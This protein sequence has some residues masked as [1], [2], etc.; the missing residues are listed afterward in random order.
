MKIKSF[1]AETMDQAFQAA[2]TEMGEEALILNTREAPSEFRHFGK[3]EVVCACANPPQQSAPPPVP[4]T[5]PV[6]ST[7]VIAAQY[8][9]IVVLVGPSGAGKTS[10]C[11][12]IA[13]KAKCAGNA[14]PALL[15]WDSTRVG[16][17][18]LLRSFADIS[19]IPIRELE[20]PEDLEASLHELR[21]HDLLIVDTPAL[22]IDQDLALLIAAAHRK[23]ATAGDTVETH[24]VLSG[25]FSS[26]YLQKCFTRYSIF[27]PMFLLPTHLDEATLDL[28]SPGLES[29]AGLRLEWCAT[30]RAVPEDLQ[31][32]AQVLAKA[33]AI[34][35]APVPPPP[36][37][38]I[39]SIEQILT[40]FRR[41]EFPPSTH[42]I[43]TS[44]RSAA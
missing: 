16:G 35:P 32:A 4:L 33:A 27:N 18:D 7:P 26:V 13:I 20:S 3:Y 31:E 29:L 39:T 19:G 34:E 6:P 37:L 22:S 12:K 25:A 1:Y 5:T 36:V 17:P 42:L 28:S 8:R 40:R 38:E 41:E 44:T 15:T 43:R 30:G 9:R 11:A 24:L 21:S 23:L 14:S 10:C 2:T